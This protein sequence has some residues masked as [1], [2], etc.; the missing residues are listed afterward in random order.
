VREGR[1]AVVGGGIFGVTAAHLVAST[2]AEVHL[3]EALDDILQGASGINQYRLHRGYHYP[4]SDSTAIASKE[5][6]ASFRSLYGEAVMK[7]GEH[8]YGIAARDSKTSPKAF[9]RF[10]ERIGLSFEPCDSEVVRSE[11]IASLYKVE[12]N[13]I[14]LTRLRDLCHRLMERSGVELHLNTPVMPTDLNEFD[15]VVNATYAGL[16]RL[17]PVQERRHYQFEICEKPVVRFPTSLRDMSVVILDGP[18][19]CVDPLGDTGR[20]VLGNVVH[21]IHHTNVGEE[22]EVP[23]ELQSLLNRGVV[24]DPPVTNYPL[25]LEAASE[26]LVGIEEA[27][28]VGSM[29]TV[30]TVLPDVDATDER[31]TFVHR[32][33]ERMVTLFSGKIGTCVEAAQSVVGAFDV[34]RADRPAGAQG[35]SSV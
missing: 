12:E 15:L 26:F 33:D 11:A 19:M 14:D 13:L 10:C 21:A 8:L 9:E 32:I 28:H 22:P 29:F 20:S 5:S 27:E 35:R 17:L 30:R 24:P 34:S 16:N 25:F 4:R 1:V 6:E 23:D 2:G 7:V 18:F 31:P 3:F